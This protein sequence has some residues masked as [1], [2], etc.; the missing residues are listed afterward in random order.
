MLR[1]TT[2][3][4]PACEWLML[5]LLLPVLAAAQT[6]VS[7]RVTANDAW[8]ST[9]IRLLPGDA[10]SVVAPS[11]VQARIRARV[12]EQEFDALRQTQ[13]VTSRGTLELFLPR[14]TP[15]RTPAFDVRVTFSRRPMPMISL[16]GMLRADALRW[17]EE[18]GFPDT[19]V[20][21]GTSNMEVDRVFDQYPG[22]G[23][24]LHDVDGVGISVSLGPPPPP[25]PQPLPEPAPNPEPQPQPSA[26]EP[27]PR[28]PPPREPPSGQVPSVVGK[29]HEDA[30]WLLGKA[31]FLL[32]D[33]RAEWSIQPGGT[34][35]QQY[36]YAGVIAPLNTLVNL[37]EAN[38]LG[39]WAWLATALAASAVVV[40]PRAWLRRS[41]RLRLERSNGVRMAFSLER[42]DDPRVDAEPESP[43]LEINM[44]LRMDAGPVEFHGDV[45]AREVDEP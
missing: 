42:G 31:G 19:Q 3:R 1:S 20:D 45:T 17:L 43:G 29:S 5:A 18:R 21:T 34:V 10:F 13:A 12:G 15:D 35:L 23:K 30:A 16:S 38:R 9:R 25:A 14:L 6:A 11:H 33:A 40:G 8:Q 4:A 26:S 22:P 41:R 28:P 7:G 24:D 44:K 27:L 2:R 39:P 36:P 37:K 32:V